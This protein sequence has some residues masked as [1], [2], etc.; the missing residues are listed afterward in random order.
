MNKIIKKEDLTLPIIQYMNNLGAKYIKSSNT[1]YLENGDWR[2]V[3]FVECIRRG[4]HVAIDTKLYI[5]SK[6][7]NQIFKKTKVSDAVYAPEFFG[8]SIDDIAEI[9]S[10]KINRPY[11]EHIIC[12]LNGEPFFLEWK[13]EFERIALPF[14]DMYNSYDAM[15]IAM[16]SFHDKDKHADLPPLVLETRNWVLKGSLIAYVSGMSIKDLKHLLDEYEQ[17]LETSEK[18]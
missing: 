11:Y 10:E 5:S 1:F 17:L 4:T 7:V 3:C 18:S 12:D 6:K 2:N 15:N 8:G 14:F 9:F 16:N 13:D